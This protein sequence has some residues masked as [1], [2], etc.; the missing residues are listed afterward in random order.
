MMNNYFIDTQFGG[1][2]FT[3]PISVGIISSLGEIFYVEATDVSTGP[4][5]II[6][7]FQKTVGAR[8]VLSSKVEE[9]TRAWMRSHPGFQQGTTLICTRK[10]V[11]SLLSKLFNDESKSKKISIEL[12]EPIADIHDRVLSLCA[13]S[14][15][16]HALMEALALAAA[17]KSGGLKVAVDTTRYGMLIGLKNSLSLRAYLRRNPEARAA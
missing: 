1:V 8:F 10:P 17:Q 6:S 16:S 11:Q 7:K 4:V 9:E 2:D 14:A 13:G 5:E 12:G 3:I 15:N